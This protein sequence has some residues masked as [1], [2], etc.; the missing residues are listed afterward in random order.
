MTLAEFNTVPRYRAEAELIQVCGSRAWVR[1]MAG[2]RPFGDLDR[3]LRAASEVWWS[4]DETDWQEAFSAHPKIGATT[5]GAWSAQEQSGM[6]RAGA[7]VTTE[8]EEANQEYLAKFGYI[9]IV[10]ASGKSADEMLAILRSRLTNAPDR[11]I[12]IAADEQAKII[13]LRLEKLLKT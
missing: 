11:E 10:C 3:L 12:R 1:G 8:L 5:T 4:L 7:A 13:R 2:R 6:R 9:F